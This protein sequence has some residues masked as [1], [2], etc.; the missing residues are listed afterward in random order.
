[1]KQ[2]LPTGLIIGVVAAL[3]LVVGLVLW[4][5]GSEPDV[6]RD[7]QGN[8]ITGIDPSKIEKDPVKFKAEM[9]KLVRESN[10]A[11]GTR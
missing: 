10:A 5:K 9:D 6:Q 3:I 4:K 7:A 1:M 2:P 11:K 8:L